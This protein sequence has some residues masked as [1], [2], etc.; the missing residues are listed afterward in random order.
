MSKLTIA[1]VADEYYLPYLKVSMASVR[2]YNPK[3][4]FVILTSK[5]F[6]VPDAEVFTFLPDTD[7]F[8]FKQNDRMREGVYYKLYLPKLPYDKVLFLDADILCQRPLNELWAEKC[9][10]ICACESHNWGTIQARQLGISKYANTGVMLMN[11]KAL[12]KANFTERLLDRLDREQPNQHD[13]TLINLEFN[14]RIKW[15]DKKYNYCHNRPY[16]EPMPESDAYLL[17]YIGR[18]EKAEFLALDDFHNL[19]MLKNELSGK[20]VAIVGNSQAILGKNQG[21]EIDKHDIVIRF[22]RGFPR[23]EVGRKTDILFLACT[24]TPEELYRYKARYTV[25]RS[26]LC[27]NE[28]D[29]NVSC[30]DRRR[31]AQT[32]NAEQIRRRKETSQASTGFIAINFALS[33]GAKKIDLYGFDFFKEP[34]YYNPKGY[35][36]LHNGSAEAIK[37]LEYEKWKLLKIN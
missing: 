8:K 22:N 5:P 31:L 2:R 36:T 26:K 9:P 21:A 34:T 24:L 4:Q 11:L 17:H 16:T 29:F 18:K 10:F 19:D 1:Y 28:C 33:A 25:R 3:A 23:D 6:E 13:E 14:D 20:S 12:R 30:S 32:P 35:Q 27:L 15:L 37:I 7:K